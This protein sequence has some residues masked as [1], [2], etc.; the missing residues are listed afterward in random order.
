MMGPEFTEAR[1]WRSS[2][3]LGH[4]YLVSP[5]RGSNTG[6]RRDDQERRSLIKNVN[7]LLEAVRAEEETLALTPKRKK[8]LLQRLNLILLDHNLHYHINTTA[9][10]KR[11][12]VDVGGWV[13]NKVFGTATESQIKDIQIQL[14]QTRATEKAVVYN[15]QR[16]ITVV[17]QTRLEA[18]ATRAQFDR[19][20]AAHRQ[21][22]TDELARWASLQAV[23]RYN[24]DLDEGL[25]RELLSINNLHTT[26]RQGRVTEAICPVS[27]IDSISKLAHAY[28]L[29][30]LPTE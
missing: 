17:N 19:L 4:S 3:V 2:E 22:V 7:I 12:L 28:G 27:L 13:L 20:G 8:V 1:R 5:N 21:F 30:P 10:R 14:N 23:T 18:T 9:H 15:T 6:T 11:G 29:V 26:I 24:C 25:N 16:L